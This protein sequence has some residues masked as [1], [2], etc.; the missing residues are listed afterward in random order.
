M[1]EPL[2]SLTFVVFVGLLCGIVDFSA[3]NLIPLSELAKRL[4]RRRRGRPVSPS[5]PHRWRYPGLRGIRL[6]CI[7]VGGSWCTTMS[8]FREFCARLSALER[9]PDGPSRRGQGD[10]ADGAEQ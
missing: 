5:T 9:P 10:R 2:A 6:E 3:E 7:R 1:L 8:A 4:P